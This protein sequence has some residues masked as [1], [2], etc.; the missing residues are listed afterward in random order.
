MFFI[1]FLVD[2][3][4]QVAASVLSLL[5]VFTWKPVFFAPQIP[6]RSNSCFALEMMITNWFVN[7]HSITW[8]LF[9]SQHTSAHTYKWTHPMRLPK[10]IKEEGTLYIQNGINRIESKLCSLTN[11]LVIIISEQNT[12]RLW[13]EFEGH[14]KIIFGIKTSADQR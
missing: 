7:E 6:P 3:P 10:V 8:T 13:E 4:A 2:Q 12:N 11:Q 5:P 1:S 9:F 14:K